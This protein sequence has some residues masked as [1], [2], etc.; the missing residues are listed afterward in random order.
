M[1][2]ETGK[3]SVVIPVFNREKLVA[4]TLESMARQTSRDFELILV[5]NNSTDGT[6]STLESWQK[7]LQGLGIDTVLAKCTTPGA[8]AARNTGLDLARYEWILFFDSDDIMPPRHIARAIDAINDHPDAEIIGWDVTYHTN[9]RRSV[10]TFARKGD[11][12]HNLMHGGM[13]TQRWC[14]RTELVRRVGGWKLDLRYWD[15]IE[16]G[17]RMLALKPVIY[18]IGLSGI[19]VI[20]QEV[21][22]TGTYDCD[23]SRME[24]ALRSIEQ[25]LGQTVWTDLKRT[26]EYALTER[27]GNRQGRA[28]MAELLS[29]NSGARKM[30]YRLAYLQTRLGIPGAARLAKFYFALLSTYSYR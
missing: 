14:A 20:A 23:P 25:V 11:Q 22:I 2:V 29:R 10:K 18:Y 8:P 9:G 30:I 13:A 21:S 5:D 27:A 24:P 4:S 7:K 1:A 6:Y 3:I 17:C 12:W 16:L 15:D 19:D 28:M 26:I